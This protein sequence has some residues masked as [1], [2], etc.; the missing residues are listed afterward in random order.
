MVISHA[1]W[2]LRIPGNINGSFNSQN[3]NIYV[4]IM[5]HS[6]IWTSDFGYLV[7]NDEEYHIY[8]FGVIWNN[9]IF[10]VHLLVTASIGLIGSGYET[11][12]IDKCQNPPWL[13]SMN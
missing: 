13:R 6:H 1:D 3:S 8:L 5:G 12:T 2:Y 11:Y 7:V 10:L 9:F 4:A